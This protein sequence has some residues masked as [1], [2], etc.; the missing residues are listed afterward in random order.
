ME[1]N[2]Q[3]RL[4]CNC[5][6]LL[7]SRESTILIDAPNAPHRKFYVL[8]KELKEQFLSG[9][10]DFT[11]LDGLFY[12][13]THPDHCERDLVKRYL[14]E[15]PACGSFLPSY[16]EADHGILHAGA[17]QVEYGYMR[18]MEVAEGMT[19]HYAFLIHAV[20]KTIYITADAE[21]S[22]VLHQE[23]LGGRHIDA[24]FWNPYYLALPQMREWMASLKIPHNYV[25]HLPADIRDETGIRRKC[26][27][28]FEY[29]NEELQ[30]FLLL[31]DYPSGNLLI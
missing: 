30:N 20:G 9:K 23:F 10:G 17:F 28:N 29:Y 16:D 3:I 4:V 14:N 7:K 19:K 15:H 2:L 1:G 27:R 18:H 8:D 11:C 22:P 6:L 24:A 26:R 13:H 31:T 25:Y 12:T 5:G 21:A